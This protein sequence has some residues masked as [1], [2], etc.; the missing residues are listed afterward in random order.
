MASS[1]P[2]K[3]V[4]SV[5]IPDVEGFRASFQYNYF[6]NDERTNDSGNISNKSKNALFS[7]SSISIDSSTLNNITVK[8]PRFIRFDFRKCV[9]QK[10]LE[11]EYRTIPQKSQKINDSVHGSTKERN[12][13]AKNIDKIISETSFFKDGFIGIDFQDDNI[14]GKL[15]SLISGSVERHIATS[16]KQAITNISAAKNNLFDKLTKT[17]SLLDKAKAYSDSTQNIKNKFVIDALNNIQQLGATF[18]DNATQS[19]IINNKFEKIKNTSIRGQI[20]KM[21]FGTIIE[22]I[23]NDPMSIFSDE[24][25]TAVEPAQ[26]IETLSISEQNAK[27]ITESEYDQSIACGLEV[28]IENN[29]GAQKINNFNSSVEIIGYII[30]KIEILPNGESI[31]KEPIIIEN[32]STI[33]AFD[34]KIKYGSRYAYSARSV[35]LAKFQAV[36]GDTNDIIV[37]CLL[38]GSKGTPKIVIDCVENVSPPHPVDFNISWDYHLR[39]P[40]LMWNL[41]PTNR[42]KDIKR[43]QIFRRKSI[44]D[45][46]QLIQEYDFDD[47]FVRTPTLETSDPS[48]IL[49]LNSPLTY[50]IDGEFKK[51]DTFIYSIC[52]VDAHGF[53]SNYSMQFEISFDRFKNKIVKKLISNS[54]APK[55]YPNMYLKTLDTFID[56]IKNSGHTKMDIYFDP[57][58]L[59]IVNRDGNSMGLLSTDRTGGK[60]KL[61]I[62]N[63]DVQKQETLEINLRDYRKG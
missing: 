3:P 51:E 31:N 55:S 13:I 19:E 6:I 54:G 41:P 47:S 4:T 21:F 57:E 34:T 24:F 5:N 25:A 49:Y 45:A 23:A 52:S 16:N 26:A 39:A 15:F 42:Q 11:N 35:A 32:P 50:F 20:N 46:F 48:L 38:V 62:I 63:V 27:T 12:F 14:D 37:L 8:S 53:S 30:D 43:F 44:N 7:K 36:S 33:L 60:Y 9:A 10:D 28:D 59:E 58:F 22:N 61:G 18:T 1:F 2:S 56:T 29:A 17:N 40:R